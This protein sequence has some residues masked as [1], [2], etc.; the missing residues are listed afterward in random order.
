MLV[1]GF[2]PTGSYSVDSCQRRNLDGPGQVTLSNEQA[3]A[4]LGSFIAARIQAHSNVYRTT[5]RDASWFG[6]YKCEFSDTQVPNLP[7]KFLS[8]E[9]PVR[10]VNKDF[11]RRSEAGEIVLSPF[12]NWNVRLDYQ[13]G[14]EG[15]ID[16]SVIHAYSSI[17]ASGLGTPVSKP[18]TSTWCT[19][20]TYQYRGRL[21]L[22][23]QHLKNLSEK[24][25]YQLG[26]TDPDGQV[27]DNI[28]CVI[29]GS[30]VQE[31]LSEHNSRLIDAATAMAEMP[32]TVKS[33]VQGCKEVL[34][35]YK[36]AKRKELRIKNLVRGPKGSSVT[37]NKQ[38]VKDRKDQLDAIADV[39]LNFRYNITPTK[40]LIEDMIKYHFAMRTEYLR[41]RKR[42]DRELDNFINAPGW[43]CSQ[44]ITQVHRVMIKA[45][46]KADATKA[47]AYLSTNLFVTAWVS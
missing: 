36:D 7:S 35:L 10:P 6:P 30:D 28:P 41:S 5:N 9:K 38:W 43:T 32:E 11:R 22:D 21:R 16:G 40:I 12:F 3:T 23:Y 27:F 18:S 33:I 25:P 24:T 1:K 4:E 17:S 29:H 8:C 34:R 39:W 44:P 37:A 42:V 45:R 46:L 26:W 31:E 13:N 19:I 15:E 47:D 2:I 20:G 14:V